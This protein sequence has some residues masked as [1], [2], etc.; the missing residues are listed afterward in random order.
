MASNNFLFAKSR[1]NTKPGAQPASS[2]QVGEAA[3]TWKVLIIDDDK[4]VH[5]TTVFALKD[6][7]FLGKQ[8]SFFH[9]HNTREAHEALESRSDYALILLDVVMDTDQAGLDLVEAVRNKYK[10]LNTQIILR[11]GQPGYAPELDAIRDYDINDYKDKSELTRTKLYTVVTSS[12]RSYAQL[13]A[14]EASK[15]GLEMIV[16]A[17]RELITKKRL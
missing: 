13:S 8:L 6:T 4:D 1:K 12:I 7:D 11:T 3:D 17:S 15:L 5:K 9:A 2:N 16:Q 10:L 14:L